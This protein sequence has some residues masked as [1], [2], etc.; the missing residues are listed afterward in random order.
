[1]SEVQ[2]NEVKTAEERW[3]EFVAEVR[4]LGEKYTLIGLVVS[5]AVG[6]TGE[7]D[8]AVITIHG[9]A[10]MP[11]LGAR[12]LYSLRGA[13][14]DSGYKSA[15]SAVESILVAADTPKEDVLKAEEPVVKA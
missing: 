1:M 15:T 11:S 12:D 13:L 10:F 2:V 6:T 9:A 8:T 4:A 3:S 5:G 14:V 7:G